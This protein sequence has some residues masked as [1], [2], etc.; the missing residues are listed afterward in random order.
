[1][2]CGRLAQ[3]THRGCVRECNREGGRIVAWLKEHKDS[4]SAQCT[5]AARAAMNQ[6]NGAAPDASGARPASLT[7]ASGSA[8]DSPPMSSGPVVPSVPAANSQVGPSLTL[9]AT[10][11]AAGEKF[12]ERVIADTEHQG[13]RAATIHVPEKWSF[14]SKIEWHY[15]WIEYPMSYSAHAENPD[16]AEAYFQYPL[17]RLESTEVAPQFRQYDTSR[18][19]SPGERLPTGAFYSP[20]VPAM[21]ALAIFIQ[22]TRANVTNLKWLGQQ[23]LPDLAKDLKLEPWPNQHGV[24]IKIGYDLNGQPVEEVFFGVYY[25][26]Q[27]ANAGVNAGMIKQTNWGFQAL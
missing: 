27:G 24:A 7:N 4:L 18:R 3:R 5:Q 10:G 8:A 9:N 19:M 11:G 16:N 1:M 26:S 20:P 14:K 2:R 17:L 6:G 23:D 22:K 21:K 15:N 13:M 25:L 12:T